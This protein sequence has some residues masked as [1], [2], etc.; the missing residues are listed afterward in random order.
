MRSCSRGGDGEFVMCIPCNWAP[1]GDGEGAAAPNCF[2]FRHSDF[3]VS[4]INVVGW[5]ILRE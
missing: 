2:A 5:Y 4:Y 3:G 1:G